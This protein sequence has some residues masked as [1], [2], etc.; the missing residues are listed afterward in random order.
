M[1]CH[2]WRLTC[3]QTEERAY[4]DTNTCVRDFSGRRHWISYRYLFSLQPCGVKLSFMH[5]VKQ[6]NRMEKRTEQL[7]APLTSS[8][9]RLSTKA[10]VGHSKCLCCSC[11][12]KGTSGHPY[13]YMP[14]GSGIIFSLHDLNYAFSIA[15]CVKIPHV[16]NTRR[17]VKNWIWATLLSLMG[18][19]ESQ[20]FHPAVSPQKTAAPRA[21]ALPTML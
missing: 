7:A 15:S 10:K 17:R 3:V 19:L 14:G 4:W 5:S 2:C 6:N 21:S 18:W 9:I 11:S 16:W 8:S 13:A 12:S 20:R 1:W